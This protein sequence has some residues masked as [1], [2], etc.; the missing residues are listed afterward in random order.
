MYLLDQYRG[1]VL[2]CR[3]AVPPRLA[4]EESRTRLEKTVK[5]A[6][7][8][9]VLKHPMLQVGMIDSTSKFPSWIQL[10]SLDLTRHIKWV[11]LDNHADFEQTVQ[12][13]FRE[14]LDHDIPVL[15]T[16]QPGWRITIIRQGYAPILEILLTWNHPQ[17]DGAGA[18]VWH[19]DFV[20]ILNTGESEAQERAGLNGDIF[21]LPEAPPLLPTPIEDLRSLPLDVKFFAK[22]IWE[23]FRPQFLNRD[24]SLAAWCPIQISP[25]KTQFRVFSMNNASL[26]AILALCRKNKTTITGLLNGLALVAF[27]LRLDSTTAPAFQSSTIVDHRR[28]LPPAPPD[29]PWGSSDRAVSNYVTQLLHRFEMDSVA[30]I[31]SKLPTNSGEDIKLSDELQS[32]LWAVSAQNRLEI[33]RKL[34]TGLRNDIVGIFKYVTDWQKTMSDMAKKPRQ[35]TWLVTNVGVLSGSTSDDEKW[36]INRAQFG[37]SAEVPAAAI[38]LAQ[39]SVAGHGMCVSANWHDCAVDVKFGERIMADLERW[40]AQLASQS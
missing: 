39:A 38:E 1:T 3:Y 36:S 15:S 35:F 29:A 23:E 30:R 12:E 7:A 21:R 4:A 17:F 20:E 14:Q 2:S 16:E 24:N 32:E 26:T 33:V 6:V 27:A 19:E 11:Y 25:Y 40:L 31:R 9:T 22:T 34:E 8:D 18:K 13:I 5:A 10:R 28:N 37:L